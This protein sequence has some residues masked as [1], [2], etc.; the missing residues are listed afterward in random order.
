MGRR[1]MIG[2]LL[3]PHGVRGEIVLERFGNDPTLVAKGRP[4]AL[5]RGGGTL[6]I[7]VTGCRP[8]PG[9]RW[10]LE[11]DGVD[12][13]EAAEAL[14]G[15][16]VIV[17][18]SELPELDEGGYYDFQVIG[19]R[20]VTAGGEPLGTVEDVLDT[21]ANDVFVVRGPRGEILIPS[22]ASV[23][24]EL[25]LEG[26]RVVITPIPGLIPE[27]EGLIPETERL[28]PEPERPGVSPK[29]EEDSP[30]EES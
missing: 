9:G 11:L 13:R 19:L 23:I 4:I 10:L 21:G 15:S 24:Q 8:G 27:A 2:R 26:G 18:E 3:K 22:I 25:D 30:S 14:R 5:E 20:A 7:M 12:S 29:E 16:P 17:D 1:I 28:I 6:E